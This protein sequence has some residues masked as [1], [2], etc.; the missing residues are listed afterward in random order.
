[1][2]RLSD[3]GKFWLSYFVFLVGLILFIAK[4]L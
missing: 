2:T 1:M 3:A 4:V